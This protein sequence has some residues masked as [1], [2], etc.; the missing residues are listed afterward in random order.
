[1]Q[2]DL[3]ETN[4]VVYKSA[5]DIMVGLGNVLIVEH[6]GDV[7]DLKGKLAVVLKSKKDNYEFSGN[8]VFP[9]G[10]TRCDSYLKLQ[11][12]KNQIYKLQKMSLLQRVAKEIG[13]AKEDLLNIH[14]I[15][16][17]DNIFTKYT[18]IDQK[19]RYT[20]ISVWQCTSKISKLK[21]YD[22]SVSQP[23]WIGIEELDSHF[24][25]APTNYYILGRY[26]NLKGEYT[27]LSDKVTS[28]FKIAEKFCANAKDEVC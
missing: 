12:F 15:F 21:S 16:H 6:H 19:T 27:R 20:K 8:L 2:Y 1:M 3:N 11:T 24:A 4:C 5:K 26:L 10:M 14:Q 22:N 9:G 25:W 17:E 7:S 28:G 23:N 13:L 18:T